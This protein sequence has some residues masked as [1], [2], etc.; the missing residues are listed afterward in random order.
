[1]ETGIE[2]TIAWWKWDT[3]F[4]TDAFSNLPKGVLKFMLSDPFL[5]SFTW[6]K[7]FKFFYK[8]NLLEFIRDEG[9][10][11]QIFW[12]EECNKKHNVKI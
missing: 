2:V 10:T 8:L 4:S 12:P 7:I 1:M 3:I 11:F 9:F 5:S 6:L